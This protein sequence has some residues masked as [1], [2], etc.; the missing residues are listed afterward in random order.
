MS[1]ELLVA[2]LWG[3]VIVYWLWTRRP[4]TADT[5]GLFHH[6][7][8]VLEHAT[9]TRVAPANRLG[10][11]DAP[12]PAAPLALAPLAAAAGPHRRMVARRR[13]RDVLCL[14]SGLVLVT[15]LVAVTTG[16]AAALA[17]QVVSDLALACYLG[18]LVFTAPARAAGAGPRRPASLGTLPLA[19]RAALLA[20][21]PPV[22]SV[23]PSLT[24]APRRS[25]APAPRPLA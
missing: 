13:R 10:A 9:P 19:P 12:E 11:G 18:L 8:R 7:L 5:V 25:V 15:V 6:E 24:S 22:T 16:S 3:V 14:L 1:T 4:T 23:P 17:F 20:P 2:A 21:V